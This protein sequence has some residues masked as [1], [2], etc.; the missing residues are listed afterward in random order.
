MSFKS[1]A[2]DQK[3]Q[4]GANYIG[5]EIIDVSAPIL[6]TSAKLIEAAQA[7]MKY[8]LARKPNLDNQTGMI[9]TAR[10]LVD[11]LDLILVAAEA[12]VNN[13]PDAIN[14]V[15]AACNI[16]SGAIA[17]FQAECRQKEGSPE[18]N[19]VIQNITDQI[20]E[21]IKHVRN[22]GE[23]AQRK[24]AEEASKDVKTPTRALNKMVEKLNAEAKVVEAKRALEEAEN[25]LK[26]ARQKK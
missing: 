12:I 20:Q 11:S 13:D 14:K 19:D 6:N 8:C 9:N 10:N 2:E 24:Q 3:V 23:T 1:Q 22:F 26:Q 17:H 18:L 5:V 15:L 4:Q 7:Q 16:I 21:T 25:R